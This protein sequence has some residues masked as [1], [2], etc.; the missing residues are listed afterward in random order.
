MKLIKQNDSAGGLI[1]KQNQNGKAMKQNYNFGQ[2]FS[3]IS[4]SQYLSFPT[5]IGNSYNRWCYGAF[6][7]G[8]NNSIVSYDMTIN[9]DTNKYLYVYRDTNPARMIGRHLNS[10]NTQTIQAIGDSFTKKTAVLNATE[11]TLSFTHGNVTTTIAN[12]ASISNIVFFSVGAYNQGSGGMSNVKFGE[13]FFYQRNLSQSEINYYYNNGL[14]NELL[15]NLGLVFFLKM[16][17]A[18]VLNFE[19]AIGEAVGIRDFSGNNNHAKIE[20]L[21]AGTLQEQLDY[22]NDNLFELW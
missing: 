20:N 15:N 17:K 18:E 16:E 5:L 10:D 21:P 9:H 8:L 7:Q 4:K 12:S 6:R 14:G 3:V 22:A 11:S 19:G 13:V 1:F 2:A